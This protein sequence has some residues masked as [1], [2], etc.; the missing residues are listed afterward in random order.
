MYDKQE[1]S[2]IIND[3][4][5]SINNDV[6]SNSDSRGN[7]NNISNDDVFFQDAQDTMNWM[8]QKVGTVAMEDCRFQSFFAC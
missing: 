3:T 7:N 4:S 8:S 2:D 6:A 5:N 1:V